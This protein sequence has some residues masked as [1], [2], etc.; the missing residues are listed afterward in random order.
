MGGEGTCKLQRED[1]GRI[2]L[3][4]AVQPA[5]HTTCSIGYVQG[6]RILSQAIAQ[7]QREKSTLPSFSVLLGL[8]FYQ[9]RTSLC[10]VSADRN[11]GSTFLS[12]FLSQE[13]PALGGERYPQPQKESLHL[14]MQFVLE[15]TLPECQEQSVEENLIL[16]KKCAPYT[17]S[18][19]QTDLLTLPEQ[20]SLFSV[21][22]I[23]GY[24]R[25]HLSQLRDRSVW[26]SNEDCESQTL[27]DA[28]QIRLNGLEEV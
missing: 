16:G 3:E 15:Y 17:P 23:S 26:S 2:L 21:G 9:P 7:Q 10:F 11:L 18:A 27:S 28:G 1:Q 13:A 20:A 5:S 12:V 14:L 4:T 19:L 8:P 6:Q 22:C 24:F 25:C